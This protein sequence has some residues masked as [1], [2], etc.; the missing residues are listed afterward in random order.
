MIID[1]FK[2][3]YKKHFETYLQLPVIYPD[4][5]SDIDELCNIIISTFSSG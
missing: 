3:H 5:E 2:K 1:V 4:N